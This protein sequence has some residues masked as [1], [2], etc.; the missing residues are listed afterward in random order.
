MPTNL[1]KFCTQDLTKTNILQPG[2]KLI[3]AFHHT[4]AMA[5]S[6]ALS[7]DLTLPSQSREKTTIPRLVYGTA[8]KKDRTAD[9]VYTALSSGFRGIDTAAQPRHYQENLVGDG[10]RRAIADG[11]VQRKDVF[12]Q[13]KFSPIGA[14]DP[15]N[16]PYDPKAPLQEQVQVSVASSLKNLAA[17]EGDGDAYLDSVVLHSPLG[18]MEDTVL[19]W[20]TLSKYVPGQIRHLG[21]SNTPLEIVQYLLDAP[22]IKVKPSVVQNRFHDKTK[23]EVPLRALCR[24][25]G[26]VFQS[27]WTLSGNPRLVRHDV[28]TQVAK[29]ASVDQEVAF[30]SL[31]LGLGGTTILDGTT[32]PQH[33]SADLGGI[34]RI[35]SWSEGEG[36]QVWTAAL[37]KFRQLI[38][39]A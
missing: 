36:Q 3:L 17:T 38:G 1:L 29:A 14:Q 11:I 35:G 5:Q 34:E 26:V 12:L 13:T 32:S 39:E 9:L 24:E 30:Y 20:K 18:S 10:L 7:R 16:M 6:S 15:G 25:H 2:R 22:D 8:W 19:V 27:F 31:V 23:W 37:T 4:R 28:V 21:I 33:M